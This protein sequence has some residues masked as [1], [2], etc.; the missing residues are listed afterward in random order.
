ME[1]ENFVKNENIDWVKEE[2]PYP[3][4][5][6]NPIDPNIYQEDEGDFY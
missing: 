1:S 6:Q 4:F 2:H 5:L 3:D